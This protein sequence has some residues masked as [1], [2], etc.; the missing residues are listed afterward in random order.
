MAKGK[1]PLGF[2]FFAKPDFCW[3]DLRPMVFDNKPRLLGCQLFTVF[4]VLTHCSEGQ[5]MPT[6]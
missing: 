3:I 5:K 6:R 4:F 2:L 1:R